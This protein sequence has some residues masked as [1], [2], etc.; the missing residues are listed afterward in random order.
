MNKSSYYIN[1]S[2]V[3]ELET[4]PVRREQPS[5]EQLQDAKKKKNRRNA[6]RRN[7]Q[8]ALYMNR[9]YVAFL[10]VCVIISAAAAVMLVQIQSD[11]THHIATLE[12]QIS[13]LKADNDARYKRMSVSVDLNHIKE[14]ATSE[15]G[16]TYATEE[17]V[18]YYTVENN[19][20]MDQYSDIPEK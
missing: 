15:L 5:R 4:Q 14:V 2:T 10:S 6:A 13:D 3:R 8:R 9:G 12:S 17:Q 11:V 20:Y 18:I 16:M 1:G 7:R 19:N